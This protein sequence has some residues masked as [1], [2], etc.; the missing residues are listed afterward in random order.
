MSE[1]GDGSGAGDDDTAPITIYDIQAAEESKVR[2]RALPRLTRQALRL[3]WA[4]GRVD[5][6]IST[7]L[8]IIGGGGIVV[9][10][11]LGQQA[12]QA[13]LDAFQHGKSL[14]AVA[15]WAVAIAGV[16]GVQSFITTVQREVPTSS[17]RLVGTSHPRAGF[18]SGDCG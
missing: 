18:G 13:L 15:P 11:L 5:F 2:V 6:T 7:L 1:F 8:Q 4:A 3:A 14:T 10:L 12:L 17:R 9:L 16:A